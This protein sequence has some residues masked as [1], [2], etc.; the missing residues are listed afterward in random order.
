MVRKLQTCTPTDRTVRRKTIKAQ[1]RAL[2]P[3]VYA[4]QPTGNESEERLRLFDAIEIIR[5]A[6]SAP[7]PVVSIQFVD[8]GDVSETFED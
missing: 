1:S 2:P 4:D 8:D 5:S 3:A 6:N 7:Q